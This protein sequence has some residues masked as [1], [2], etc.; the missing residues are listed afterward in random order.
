MLTA[1]SSSSVDLTPA[2]LPARP[3]I[4]KLAK[5]FA[6]AI[7]TQRLSDFLLWFLYYD[8][9]DLPASPETWYAPLTTTDTRGWIVLGTFLSHTQAIGTEYGLD[10][11]VLD[12]I[13][14]R[15]HLHRPLVHEIFV[16]FS[17]PKKMA[18]G[19]LATTIRRAEQARMAKLP[20]LVEVQAKLNAASQLVGRLEPTPDS[21]FEVWQAAIQRRVRGLLH[22]VIGPRIA[23]VKEGKPL[24]T[25]ATSGQLP[26]EAKDGIKLNYLF[27]VVQLERGVPMDRYGVI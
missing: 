8:V 7:T 13:C 23:Q 15:L 12:S 11:V 1:P 5:S 19:I 4:S 21:Q 20:M 6:N 18:F 26:K 3:Q 16:R 25:A 10:L 17:S 27:E 9:V 22:L 2:G 14:D 24:L